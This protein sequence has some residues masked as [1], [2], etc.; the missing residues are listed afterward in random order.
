MIPSFVK[1]INDQINISPISESEILMSYVLLCV[2]TI[3][4]KRKNAAKSMPRAVQDRNAYLDSSGHC[5][6]SDSLLQ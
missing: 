1:N 4:L 5:E 6:Q 2:L 3:T